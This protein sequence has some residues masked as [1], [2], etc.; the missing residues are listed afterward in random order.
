RNASMALEHDSV[1]AERTRARRAEALEELREQLNLESLPMRIECFDISNLG[2]TN[3]VAS[4]V[5]FEDAVAKRSDYRSFTIRRGSGQDDFASM[6][7]AVSRRFARLGS[8]DADGYDRSFAAT[9]NLVVIDGGKGQLNAA[10]EAMAGFDLPRVA[11][12]SLAKREEEVFI[13]GRAD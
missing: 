4:M 9:P 2:E 10:L 13:P 3:T 5:V 1:L 8:V 7:E 11:V 12:I 6:R